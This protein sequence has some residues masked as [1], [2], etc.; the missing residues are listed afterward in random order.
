LGGGQVLPSVAFR[1]SAGVV[2]TPAVLPFPTALVQVDEIE[3]EIKREI[4]R[5]LHDDVAQSLTAVLVQMENFKAEQFGRRG[6]QSEVT[7]LQV[8]IRRALSNIRE[9]LHG[10]RGEAYVREDLVGALRNTLV[11]R[12]RETA[13]IEV[14][15]SVARAWPR[16]MS[17]DNLWNIYR[18]VQ[19]ALNN[20]ALHAA[21]SSASVR[22][23]VTEDRFAVVTIADNGRGILRL[24][25]PLKDSRFG[26]VGMRERAVLVGGDLVISSRQRKGTK[27]RLTIPLENLA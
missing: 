4:A 5:E 8:S 26:L 22:L 25:H 13:G 27:V 19:E 17:S 9:L 3:R 1:Q 6:V 14:T 21:A 20:A 11:K 7:S 2:A 10:L 16:F 18:I 12:F 24:H 23:S 15:L